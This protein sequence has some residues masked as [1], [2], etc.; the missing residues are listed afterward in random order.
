M[1][2]IFEDKFNPK[3][4]YSLSLFYFCLSYFFTDL[5]S[6]K[7]GIYLK[8]S[9]VSVT[10]E[11]KKI[12]F[13][14][15]INQIVLIF[16]KVFRVFLCSSVVYSSLETEVFS[17]STCLSIDLEVNMAHRRRSTNRR[18]IYVPHTTQSVGKCH[19]PAKFPYR[20][21]NAFYLMYVCAFSISLGE[22]S[23]N[24]PSFWLG[25]NND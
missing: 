18:W 7:W 23:S 2:L 21:P 4:L 16:H 13:H 5:S 25:M 15:I 10:M 9:H 8:S 14:I 6:S 3:W 24:W 1:L 12:N 22:F 20:N 19:W 17:S 11:N